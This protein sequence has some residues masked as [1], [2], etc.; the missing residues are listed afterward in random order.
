MVKYIIIDKNG[1]LHEGNRKSMRIAYEVLVAGFGEIG[2]IEEM[3]GKKWSKLVKKWCVDFEYPLQLLKVVDS[4]KSES[5][6]D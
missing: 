2:D 1:I 3:A 4:C 5:S 6:F